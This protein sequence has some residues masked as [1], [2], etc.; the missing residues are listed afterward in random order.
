MGRPGWVCAQP[1]TD[2]TKSSAK[3]SDLPPT[4]QKIGSDRTIPAEK[5]SGLSRG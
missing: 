1:V 4:N 3:F 2:P 5:W